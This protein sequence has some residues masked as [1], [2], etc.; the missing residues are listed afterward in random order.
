MDDLVDFPMKL[1]MCGSNSFKTWKL[2][3]TWITNNFGISGSQNFKN[4][5]KVLFKQT[6]IN[7]PRSQTLNEPCVE[8]LEAVQVDPMAFQVNYAVNNLLPLHGCSTLAC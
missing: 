4:S 5:N 8:C 6:W 7:F 3:S 2:E 1:W